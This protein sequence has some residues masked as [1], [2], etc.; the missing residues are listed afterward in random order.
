MV[1]AGAR[2]RAGVGF[3]RAGAGELWKP[4]CVAQLGGFALGLDC[5]G[6]PP[7]GRLTRDR[8]VARA[9]QRSDR[10]QAERKAM[11]A[12]SAKSGSYRRT[13]E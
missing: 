13:K 1:R 4:A 9:V 5:I 10:P 2:L 8:S 6:T 7:V 11:R 12:A 3:H